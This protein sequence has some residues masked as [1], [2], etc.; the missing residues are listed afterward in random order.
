MRRHR[1]L[2]SLASLLIGIFALQLPAQALTISPPIY[3]YTLN[4]GD[5]I[6][7][8][9]K[10]YNESEA[11]ITVYPQVYNF[12]FTEGDE[13]SGTPSFY[14]SDEIRNGYELGP[15]ITVSD[16]AVTLQPG[17]RLSLDFTVAIPEN[18][19][20]GS[21]FG[22]IQLRT[23]AE[24]PLAG[25][26]VSLVG[27]T[28]VLI[29]VRVAGTVDDAM[30][31][32]RFGGDRDFYTSLPVDFHTRLENRGNIHL[33]PTGN[34]FVTNVFG[35]QVSSIQVNG[36]FRTI[37]PQSAR[38]FDNSWFKR[39][40]QD[41]ASEFTKEWR[42]FAFGRYEALLVLNYGPDNKVVTTSW[43]FWVIPWMVLSVI[44]GGAILI[45]LGFWLALKAYNKSVIKRY[46]A[47]AANK[48]KE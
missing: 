30:T 2:L 12:T 5:S 18:A 9:V 26:T 14:K 1:I 7:D 32:T 22:S 39:K 3:D 40:V 23:S 34:I 47:M 44:V 10:L 17:Q 19:A 25:P 15:W 6:R 43:A 28:G 13:T 16:K 21:H 37:L 29:M 36:E 24:E 46:E 31:I 48:K 11:P 33:R 4:P 38:R 20:P 42:N 27:G 41:G 45:V 35:K 8:V